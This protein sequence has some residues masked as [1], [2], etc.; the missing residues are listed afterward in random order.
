MYHHT[1]KNYI[2]YE[3]KVTKFFVI[4][5]FLINFAEKISIKKKGPKFMRKLSRLSYV[6]ILLLGFS[7]G[8]HQ[9]FEHT[10]TLFLVIVLLVTVVYFI[11]KDLMK[12]KDK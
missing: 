6:L 9:H 11:S 8:F 10:V 12:N 4:Y 1:N 2:R 5:Y 3:S 7:I